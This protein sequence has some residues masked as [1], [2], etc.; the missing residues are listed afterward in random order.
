MPSIW[1]SSFI[2]LQF[3]WLISKQFSHVHQMYSHLTISTELC[4]LFRCM[5]M[6]AP[7]TILCLRSIRINRPINGFQWPNVGHFIIEQFGHLPWIFDWIILLSR[8]LLLLLFLFSLL[9]I[10]FG[11]P[12][13]QFMCIPNGTKL[14]MPFFIHILFEFIFEFFHLECCVRCFQNVIQIG[15]QLFTGKMPKSKNK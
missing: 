6:S 10:Q 1:C 14:V 4:L 8:L 15:H 5:A 11:E 13:V 3:L 7:K 12:L 2:Y 9:F